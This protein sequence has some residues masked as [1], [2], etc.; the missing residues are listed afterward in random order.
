MDDT[1]VS[2]KVPSKET[3]RG[4]WRRTAPDMAEISQAPFEIVPDG[5]GL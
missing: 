4:Q 2:P 1:K 3:I 5:Q